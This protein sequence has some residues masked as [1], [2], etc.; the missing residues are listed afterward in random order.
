MPQGISITATSASAHVFGSPGIRSHVSVHGLSVAAL[1]GALCHSA[2][3]SPCAVAQ[4]ELCLALPQ[5]WTLWSVALD[6]SA[7][8]VCA[9]LALACRPVAPCVPV[10]DP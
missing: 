2:Q 3:A 6:L 1:V 10:H 7:S 9:V 8:R 4:V 5:G